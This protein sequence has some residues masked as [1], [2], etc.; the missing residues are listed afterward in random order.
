MGN[1]RENQ[2]ALLAFVAVER[3]DGAGGSLI[4]LHQVWVNKYYTKLL[5]VFEQPEKH[6]IVLFYLN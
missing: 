3:A 1:F 5:S 4:F 6:Y 2:E